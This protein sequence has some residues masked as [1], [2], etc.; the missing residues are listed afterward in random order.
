MGN[1]KYILVLTKLFKTGLKS[2]SGDGGRGLFSAPKFRLTRHVDLVEGVVRVNLVRC[3]LLDV[4]HIL[5]RVYYLL[6][7]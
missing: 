3:L 5:D 4:L 1:I 7:E 6:K 2:R